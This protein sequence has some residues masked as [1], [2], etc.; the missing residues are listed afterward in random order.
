MPGQALELK[1]DV[2]QV[3]DKVLSYV[4]E[5]LSPTEV[6]KISENRSKLV[7]LFEVNESCFSLTVALCDPPP[8]KIRLS[9]REHEIVRL[10][11]AGLSNK[12]IAGVLDIS[13][14]TV[15]THMRRGFSKLDVNS[16]AEMVACLIKNG[17]LDLGN[18]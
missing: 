6:T 18:S 5:T 2:K 10:V 8:P 15:S 12:A 17:I 9:P 16:R 11:A 13:P 7:F 1:E 14:W 4:D 3:A